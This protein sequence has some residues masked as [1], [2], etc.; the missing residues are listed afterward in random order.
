MQGRSAYMVTLPTIQFQNFVFP[1]TIGSW[2][3]REVNRAS[4]LT[5][6]GEDSQPR[7]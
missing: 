5:L 6:S 2:L 4:L 1:G 7:S 3:L